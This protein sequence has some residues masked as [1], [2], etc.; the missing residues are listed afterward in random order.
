MSGRA[1]YVAAAIFLAAF[2]AYYV[3]DLHKPAAGGVSSP[4]PAPVINLDAAAVSQFQVKSAG[5]VL[6]VLRNGAEWRYS[7]CSVTQADCPTSVADTNRTL[8]LLGVILQLRPTK[9]IFGAPEGLP[10]YG[11]DTATVGEVDVQTPAGRSVSLLI[12]AKT[13]D[14]ASYYV[15]LAGSNDI[16]A[17]SAANVLTQIVGAIS[18]PP[19]PLPTPSPTT[20]ATASPSPG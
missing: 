17:V 9:T 10:A 3:F 14:S 5:K 6:T 16:E 7:V 8:T 4:Q 2:G 11:L 20:G 15:R 1:F 12:G 18:A 19:A 13:Q